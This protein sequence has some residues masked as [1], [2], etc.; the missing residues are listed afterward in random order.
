MM[1][2]AFTV[3]TFMELMY[4]GERMRYDFNAHL[5][6]YIGTF[7]YME[8]QCDRH[9]LMYSVHSGQLKLSGVSFVLPYTLIEPIYQAFIYPGEVNVDPLHME[10]DDELIVFLYLILDL[11]ERG[12]IQAIPRKDGYMQF[13]SISQH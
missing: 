3:N 7:D 2:V 5:A 8:L 9:N 4:S 12:N 6:R 11:Y 10:I 13:T 1:M